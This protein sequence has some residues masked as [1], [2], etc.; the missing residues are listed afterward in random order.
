MKKALIRILSVAACFAVIGLIFAA[1][2]CTNKEYVKSDIK[3][4]FLADS[5]VMKV[6]LVLAL[7]ND[8]GIELKKDGTFIMELTVNDAVVYAANKID[9]SGIAELDV[10]KEANNYAVPIVPGFSMQDIKGS[11]SLLKNSM[12]AELLIDY[13]DEN[14]IKL[15]DSLENTGRI[16]PDLIIPNGIGF[17]Y[18]GF[19]EIRTLKSETTGV[20]Y[21]AVYVDRFTEGGEPFLIMTLTNDEETG[22]R[23]LNANVEFLQ[24]NL[25]LEERV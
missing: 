10:A 1:G 24:L 17:R 23:R 5:S 12:G 18:E 14:I 3:F 16:N 13:E 25:S 19:Y 6:P 9:K 22:L 8:S 15:I 4:K 7:S 20:E 21:Q 2:G 11:L